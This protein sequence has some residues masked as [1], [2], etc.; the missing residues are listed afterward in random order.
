[1]NIIKDLSSIGI[2]DLIASG[3]ASIFWLYFASILI[4]EEYGEL[5]F[6]V[7]IVG[8]VFAF[9]MLG[10]RNSI[11]VFEAKKIKL[12]SSLFLLSIIGG[13]IGS[14]IL[15]FLH[16]RFDIIFLTMGTILGELGISYFLGKKYFQKYA[17]FVVLQKLLMITLAVIL[18]Y[19][20]GLEGI[21][22]GMGISYLPYFIIVFKK[23]KK[24][25]ID[26]PLV[27][28]H[29]GFIVNNY[30]LMFVGNIKSNL[31]KIII[32]PLIGFSDLGNYALGFQIYLIMMVFTNIVFKFTLPHDSTGSV[33]KKV[34]TFTILISI[35]IATLGIALVPKIIPNFFPQFAEV[36]DIVPIL[37]LAVIPNTIHRLFTSKFLGNEKSKFVLIGYA[38]STIIYIIFIIIF[39]E[40]LGTI[41][42]SIGYLISSISHT[43]FFIILNKKK[44]YQ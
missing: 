5:Q 2:A 27:K 44:M 20:I 38:M 15:F 13:I 6:F 12:R 43:I 40:T 32:V 17:I 29:S 41:G 1:M 24:K 30:L 16:S 26:F 18:F 36:V 19:S 4:P 35:V 23:I 11:I 14:V 39:A 34:I 33:P 8:I 25:S 37:A 3:I 7:N 22:F 28:K 21:I 10:A 31:D 9:S 42:I